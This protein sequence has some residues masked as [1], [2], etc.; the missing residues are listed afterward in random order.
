M[1]NLT[2]EDKEHIEMLLEKHCNNISFEKYFS[3]VL[4]KKYKYTESSL[5]EMYMIYSSIQIS[6]IDEYN[7]ILNS[8]INIGLK[9]RASDL[10]LQEID[11]FS[12][13]FNLRLYKLTVTF[14]KY[15]EILAQNPN[16]A[17]ECSMQD[18]KNLFNEIQNNINNDIKTSLNELIKETRNKKELTEYDKALIEDGLIDENLNA[19]HS[20]PKIAKFLVD[21]MLIDD[22]KPE[23]LLRYKVNGE[24]FKL[25]TAR[26]AVKYAKKKIKKTRKQIRYNLDI[27][28]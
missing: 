18:I 21:E 27:F 22:L 26:E 17:T 24:S 25:S 16:F 12:L 11:Q 9:S 8:Y 10:A 6:L 20:A 15:L 28:W 1:K 14:H 23:L 3:S 2:K 5:I 4:E 13:I 7:K 19:I